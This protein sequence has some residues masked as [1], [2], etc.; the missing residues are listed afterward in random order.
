MSVSR[1]LRVAAVAVAAVLAPS[2]VVGWGVLGHYMTAA[3]AQNYLSTAAT[4]GVTNLLPESNG[5][6]GTVA[7]WAD[8]VGR[9]EFT[10]SPVRRT[11]PHRSHACM[12]HLSVRTLRIRLPMPLLSLHLSAVYIPFLSPQ[13]LHFINTPDWACTYERAR[14]C[15]DD[16]V[17]VSEHAQWP[18]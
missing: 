8:Q 17:Q 5:D 18:S 4:N 13:A 14:D 16:G 12:L 3:I 9:D 15:V 6:M 7:S 1:V 11:K 2:S 10:W